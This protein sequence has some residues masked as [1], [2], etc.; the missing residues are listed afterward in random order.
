M[1]LVSLFIRP[2]LLA[3]FAPRSSYASAL[4]SKRG[5]KNYYKGKGARPTGHHTK[6]GGYRIDSWKLPDYVVPDLTNCEVRGKPE[7]S[8]AGYQPLLVPSTR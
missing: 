6:H 1:S 3:R 4:S 8:A 2:F 5:N 7:L